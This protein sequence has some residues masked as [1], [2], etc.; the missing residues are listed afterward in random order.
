LFAGLWLVIA[1]TDPSSWIIGVPT[2]ALATLTSLGLSTGEPKRSGLRLTALLRFLPFFAFESVR[3]GL[4]VASR[5]LHPRVKIDPGFQTYTPRLDHPA[6]IV[7]F[8]DSISLLPGT[9]SADLRNGVI[10]VH[11]LD[12]GSDLAPALQRLERLIGQLFGEALEGAHK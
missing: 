12:V 6:A 11:A 8:L 4:D 7:L 3:G 10:D 9:L 1:G 5:V 2:V